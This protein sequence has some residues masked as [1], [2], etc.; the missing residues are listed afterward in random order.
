[1]SAR[2]GATF[3]I[4]LCNWAE[5]AAGLRRIRYGVFVVE[6]GVPEV[7]EWDV[8]DAQS[9]HRLAED[10]VGEPIGC[11]RLLADGHIGRVAVMQEW[12]RR[13]VGSALMLR[14]IEA[15]RLRGVA[16]AIVNA[17]VVAMPFYERHGFVAN[18]EVFLEAGIPHRVMTRALR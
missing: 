16:H 2:A 11:A 14:L 9:V 17:Q 3:A 18:G 1:M 7:L 15:A 4:R 10:A 12:R 5:G 13:G 6:Q 8:A